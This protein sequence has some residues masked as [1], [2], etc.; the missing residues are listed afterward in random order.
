MKMDDEIDA[1]ARRDIKEVI[2]GMLEVAGNFWK[3][4]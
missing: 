4:H 2:A 3:H 1:D